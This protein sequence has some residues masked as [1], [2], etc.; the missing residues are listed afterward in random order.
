ML[1]QFSIALLTGIVAATLVPPVRN[2]IARP[3]EIVLWVILFAVCLVG[4]LSITN[5]NARELT[6]SAFWGVDQVLTTLVSLLGAGLVGWLA[7]NRFTIASWVTLG[8]GVDIMALAMLRSHRRSRGWQPRVRLAEWMELPRLSTAVPAPVMAPYAIDELNRKW[9]AKMAIAGATLL[10]WLVHFSIWARDV[11]MPRQAD[12][13]AHA[14]AV[15]RVE[16]RARLESL[17][18]TASQLKFAA[19]GL[20]SAAGAPAVN[21]LTARATEALRTMGRARDA[22][23]LKPGRVGDI[24]VLLGA[25]SIGWYGPMR[26][27]PTSQAEEKED[28]SGQTGRLAS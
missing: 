6:T 19:R 25:Q 2:V 13:L 15:G 24:R 10:T 7:D 17:R 8:C 9:A 23:E 21:G 18:D 5:P 3:I 26:L 1:P 20:Y 27:A 16:S 12:R 28:E 22:A 11:L 14:A 4:V